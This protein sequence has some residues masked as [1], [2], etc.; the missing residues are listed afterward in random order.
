MARG[1]RGERVPVR[2][3]PRRGGWAREGEGKLLYVVAA[4]CEVQIRCVVSFLP[5]YSSCQ[6]DSSPAKS[7][8]T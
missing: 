8:R 4:R 3:G 5:F 7:R 1:R 2:R 6:P